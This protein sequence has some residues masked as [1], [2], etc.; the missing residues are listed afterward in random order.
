MVNGDLVIDSNVYYNATQVFDVKN[1]ASVAWIVRG[2][3]IISPQ[4]STL[5]GAFFVIGD[6]TLDGSYDGAVVTQ[7]VTATQLVVYGLMMARSFD[8]QRNYQGVFGNDEPSE[9][10]YYDGRA[11]LN[12]PPGLRDFTTTL[13]LITA[14]EN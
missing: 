11:V 2:D 10:F 8:L 3:L 12:I 1:I 4:V 5:S 7:P 9:L 13:P 6:D 14:D